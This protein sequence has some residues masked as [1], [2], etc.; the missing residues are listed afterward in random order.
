[1]R[2]A[3][4]VLAQLEAAVA[5]RDRNAVRQCLR[6]L[7]RDS[8]TRMPERRAVSAVASVLRSW[9]RDATVTTMATFCTR[10]DG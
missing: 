3:S 1:M 8:L 7:V 4:R 6:S 9:P 5:S 10:G 2:S